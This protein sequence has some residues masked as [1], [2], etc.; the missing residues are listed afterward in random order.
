MPCALQAGNF[1]D[2]IVTFCVGMGIGMG[3]P[4]FLQ[5]TC[6]YLMLGEPLGHAQMSKEIGSHGHTSPKR[7][8]QCL[9]WVQHSGRA[10]T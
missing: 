9:C 10:G 1:L 2:K 5:L 8:G 7:F 6:S 3:L 4:I